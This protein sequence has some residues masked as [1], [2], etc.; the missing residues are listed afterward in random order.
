MTAL[1]GTMKEI[2]FDKQFRGYNR[3]QV[4]YYVEY[5]TKEYQIAYDEYESLFIKYNDLMMKHKSTVTKEGKADPVLI[6]PRALTKAEI[7]KIVESR[8][9][10]SAN[11]ALQAETL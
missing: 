10:E 3:E 1:Q 2:L 11:L 6:P 4:N 8:H 5:L 7:Q 9:T